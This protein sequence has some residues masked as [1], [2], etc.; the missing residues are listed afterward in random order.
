MRELYRTSPIVPKTIRKWGVDASI[1]FG[2]YVEIDLISENGL[3]TVTATIEEDAVSVFNAALRKSRALSK[4]SPATSHLQS[5]FLQGLQRRYLE[6]R[7]LPIEISDSENASVLASLYQRNM[8]SL[9]RISALE[10][11]YK[12]ARSRAE[13][14]SFLRVLTTG[15]GLVGEIYEDQQRANAER[16][17]QKMEGT[18][19]VFSEELSELRTAIQNSTSRVNEVE[20]KLRERGTSLGNAEKS[21]LDILSDSQSLHGFRDQVER[22]HDAAVKQ[23]KNWLQ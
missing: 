4:I 17:L 23:V 21:L 13:S 1:V 20:R 11:T 15:L 3:R 14:S 7:T 19:T 5:S 9:M 2:A 10:K 12:E 16:Q 22:Q 6:V 8:T 18:F